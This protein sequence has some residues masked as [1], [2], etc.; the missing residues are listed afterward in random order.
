MAGAA[1]WY[2]ERF[3]HCRPG[4]SRD[5]LPMPNTPRRVL[6]YDALPCHTGMRWTI[7]ADPAGPA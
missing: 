3:I 6:V 2:I 7:T 4:Y 1:N 5:G